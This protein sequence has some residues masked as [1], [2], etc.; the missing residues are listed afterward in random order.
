[1]NSIIRYTLL[2][3]TRD[4]LYL[5]ILLLSLGSIFLSTFLGGTAVVEQGLMSMAYMGGSCRMI[6]AIG[7]VLFVCFHVRRS[8]DNKEVELI[9]T[10]PISR[11]SFVLAYYLAFAILSFSMVLPLMLLFLFMIKIGYVWGSYSGVLF[12]GMSF[13]FETLILIGFAFFASLILESAVSSVLG[14]FAFYFLGRIFGFFLI[15]INNPISLTHSTS[16]GK[17]TEQVLNVIG[18]FLPRL[19]MF[20]KSEWLTYGV[21]DYQQFLMFF[22][23]SAIYIP[24]LITMAVFDFIRK[25]F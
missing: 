10:K 5:G 18:V 20:A 4:W 21:M 3:A 17:F 15:S 16:W 6:M 8:F 22:I 19:D 13:Y 2:T 11:T 23:T 12:W 7:L 9:L 1:M 25:E 24:L 14:T